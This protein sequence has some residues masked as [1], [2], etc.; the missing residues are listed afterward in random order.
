MQ[1]SLVDSLSFFMEL[2]N[3]VQPDQAVN[4]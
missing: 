4:G 1:Q 2:P 3:L